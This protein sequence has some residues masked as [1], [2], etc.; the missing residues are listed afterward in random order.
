M[1]KLRKKEGEVREQERLKEEQK[2]KEQER[3]HALVQDAQKWHNSNI[4]RTYIKAVEETQ[5]AEDTPD[6]L[7]TEMEAWIK[8]AKEQADIFDPMLNQSWKKNS[9]LSPGRYL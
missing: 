9:N 5:T 7:K 8:W 6:E 4:L 3:F 2:K 1:E